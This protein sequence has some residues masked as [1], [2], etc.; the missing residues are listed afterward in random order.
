MIK[1]RIASTAA[2]FTFGLAALGGAVFAAP[3]SAAPET[4]VTVDGTAM[5]G[6][7]GPSVEDAGRVA[8]ELE[9][10]TRGPNVTG[11]SA[12]GSAATKVHVLFPHDPA[13][14]SDH[15]GQGHKGGN[16]T[17]PE[18]GQPPSSIGHTDTV[19]GRG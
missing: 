16:E 13:P 8:N 14:H 5:K 6:T 19:H 17:R 10:A 18:P 12:P 7:A 15:N 1:T 9:S 2:I 3:A 4:T 11:V